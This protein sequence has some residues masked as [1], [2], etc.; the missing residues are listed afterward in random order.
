MYL[1]YT[2]YLTLW[3]PIIV[4]TIQLIRLYVL[5]CTFVFCF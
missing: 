5:T 4:Q 1:Y 3:M 2:I